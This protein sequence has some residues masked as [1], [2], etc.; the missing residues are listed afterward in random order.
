MGL[1]TDLTREDAK[2]IK[3]AKTINHDDIIEIHEYL[4]SL[5]SRNSRPAQSRR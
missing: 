1:V 5:D 2:K 3:E 4:E